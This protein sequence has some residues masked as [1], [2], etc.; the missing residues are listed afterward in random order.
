[1]KKTLFYALVAAA[2]IVLPSC[3]SAQKENEKV[4]E[5]MADAE[6]TELRTI[7]GEEATVEN[8]QADECVLVCNDDSKYRPDGKVEKLT[9]IDFSA[10]WCGPCKI[11]APAFDEAA[12]Q[13]AGKADFVS[14]DIDKCP[15]T[16]AAFSVEAVPTVV[17]L[18]PDGKNLRYVGTQDILP[19]DKFVKIVTENL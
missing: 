18:R 19:L 16:A 8:A 14:V 15:E 12:K 6:A 2:A 3:G 7:T 10:T 13:F 5:A 9:L 17:V 1:M 4:N 11:F